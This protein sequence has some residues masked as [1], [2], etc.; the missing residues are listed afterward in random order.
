MSNEDFNKLFEVFARDGWEGPLN[1]YKA[2]LKNVDKQVEES[3]PNDRFTVS[4]PVTFIA[5]EN[6]VIGRPEIA[7]F[8]AEQGKQRGELLDV[9]VEVMPGVAHWVMLEA[10]EA[11]FEM[12]EKVAQKLGKTGQNSRKGIDTPHP[13]CEG[14]DVV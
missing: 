6:D 13:P 14:N 8:K 2:A 7:S 5:G 12:L 11:T 10:S 1:W 9:N 4:C 3:I